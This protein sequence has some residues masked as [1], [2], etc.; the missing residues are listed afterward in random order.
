MTSDSIAPPSV[1]QKPNQQT[2]S[3]RGQKEES[4]G[5][6]EEWKEKEGTKN[7]K[8]E[9]PQ[10]GRRE[11]EKQANKQTMKMSGQSHQQMPKR[12]FVLFWLFFQKIFYFFKIGFSI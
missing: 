6:E 11:R 5:M 12:G 1:N 7:Q 4:K 8:Q 10:E 3:K 2:K 9:P